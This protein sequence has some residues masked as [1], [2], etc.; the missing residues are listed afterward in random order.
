MG[1]DDRFAVKPTNSTARQGVALRLCHITPR[2]MKL[3]NQ[4]VLF[5]T[6]CLLLLV[7]L[8]NLVSVV[9]HQS[10]IGPL[11]T[12][13]SPVPAKPP[14]AAPAAGHFSNHSSSAVTIQQKQSANKQKTPVLARNINCAAAEAAGAR[15][16]GSNLTVS[17]VQNSTTHSIHDNVVLTALRAAAAAGDSCT[18]HLAPLQD[19]AAHNTTCCRVSS[20]SINAV[21]ASTAAFQ[22]EAAA[23]AAANS[24]NAETDTSSTE[25]ASNLVS[26]LRGKLEAAWKQAL[27]PF[28]A[29]NLPSDSSNS[30][31]TGSRC[32]CRS[33]EVHPAQPQ[34]GSSSS[35]TG[36]IVVVSSWS[37]LIEHSLRI[38]STSLLMLWF[39]A[40]MHGYGLHVYV[41]GADLPD[42]MPVFFV[43]PAGILHAMQDLRYQQVV[44]VDWDMLLSPD[45]AP[46][47]SLF[48]QEYPYASLLF[49][50]EQNLAAGANLWRNT[51]DARAVLHA[52]WDLGARGCCPTIQH[53][54]TALKHIVAAY[55]ADLTGDASVYAPDKDSKQQSAFKLPALTS[56]P[57]PRR[58]E[59]SAVVGCQEFLEDFEPQSCEPEPTPVETWM[60]L[61]P[62]LRERRSA[63]GLVALIVHDSR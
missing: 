56:L 22:L 15:V 34:F 35:S 58:A 47:L 55:L 63:I 20:S 10:H 61:R 54:Q 18:R 40:H 13:H 5:I 3:H 32:Q 41:H 29:G 46:P 12:V 45:T 24:T 33:V 57:L 27:K 17:S 8:D 26:D 7:S 43:K 14:A 16:S 31:A 38:Y 19:R 60:K 48:Y 21:K 49:Q 39:Y 23:V 44:Y 62:V 50:G 53:D 4:A 9:L 25:T 11:S 59:G 36:I 37:Y 42:Y 30:N 2:V 51:A 6:L 52:W 28:L 1:N